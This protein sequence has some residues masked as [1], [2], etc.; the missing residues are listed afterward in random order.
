MIQIWA[1][2]LPN[3]ESMVTWNVQGSDILR[4]QNM[5]NLGRSLTTKNAMRNQGSWKVRSINFTQIT[6]R[7]LTTSD[8]SRDLLSH[9]PNSRKNTQR[10]NILYCYFL[11]LTMVVPLGLRS[12]TKTK[13]LFSVTLK[14][15]ALTPSITTVQSSKEAPGDKN[16]L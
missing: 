9:E 12:G 14:T 7:I 4:V 10:A 2:R 11:I 15:S 1:Y 5:P 3:N 6:Y 8:S 13:S 16:V